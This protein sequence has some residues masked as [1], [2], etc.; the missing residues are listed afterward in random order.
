M[1]FTESIV[2]DAAMTWFGEL[3]YEV[4]HGSHLGTGEPK[5]KRNWR[6]AE[7]GKSICLSGEDSDPAVEEMVASS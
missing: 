3:G 1:F 7:M 4:G 5:V 2:E 6:A